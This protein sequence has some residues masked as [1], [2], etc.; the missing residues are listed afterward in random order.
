MTDASLTP[1]EQAALHAELETAG[2]GVKPE[3]V[4]LVAGD[5]AF[6][7]Q[8]PAFE[9]SFELF[10]L[11]LQDT[12][13]KTLK[14]P[15]QVSPQPLEVV[16]PKM[17]EQTLA[18]HTGVAE[19]V[20]QSN[21]LQGYCAFN[22]DF[23]AAVVEQ[24][25]G[26]VPLGQKVQGDAAGEEADDAE[27]IED[28]PEG[29]SAEVKEAIKQPLTELERE[30]FEMFFGKVLVLIQEHVLA[31]ANVRLKHRYVPFG[32]PT[33]VPSDLDSV[34]LCRF[35]FEIAGSQYTLD[36][37]LFVGLMKL[38]LQGESKS[39]TGK[40]PEWMVKHLARAD[41]EVTGSLGHIELSLA[42]LL[43]LRAGDVLRLDRGRHDT[44]PVLIEGIHK[45]NAKPVQQH[46][47]FGVEIQT[48]LS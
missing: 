27:P 29:E 14:T 12:I 5:R 3:P 4:D 7:E 24:V 6:R 34:L 31:G 21:A 35:D 8:V 43:G 18:A 33:E 32:L 36:L 45:F 39:G 19:I 9:R 41:I 38:G 25:F 20:D 28:A 13:A 42:D 26:G 48:E 1:E 44:V 2:R 46:G 16:G 47:V 10:K 15:C 37:V 22:D 30:T 40:R 23:C 17:I 11:A